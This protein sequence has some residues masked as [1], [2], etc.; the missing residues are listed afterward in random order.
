MKKFIALILATL[1]LLSFV[2]CDF[3]SSDNDSAK[4]KDN[5]KKNE[6]NDEQDDIKGEVVFSELVV[7][8]NAECVIKI[9]EINPD[10]MWGYK[11]KVQLENKSADKTYMFA[12]EDAAINGVQ[13]DPLF[14]AEVTAGKKANKDITFTT[15]NFEENGIKN[16][17][18]IELNFRVYDS[19][20]WGAEDVVKKT[21]HVYPYG[22]DK[23]SKFVRA[24]QASDKIILDNEY[25]TV[26]ATGFEMD[27]IWGYKAK[28]FFINKTNKNLMFSVNDASVNGYM[29]D[30]FFSKEVSADKCAFG[31]MTWSN[32][33]FEKNGITDVE[34]IEFNL[35]IYDNDDWFGDDLVNMAVTLIP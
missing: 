29:A 24:S 21:V 12:V 10:N 5:A 17:T 6:Q 34:K 19:D 8:D 16:F 1:M 26:I 15:T 35:R 31:N 3:E 25:V 23:A 33:E 11:L 28:L 20:D 30:P 9:T 27:D 18:D 4:D 13:C 2:A 7:V 22:E 32:S 14:A